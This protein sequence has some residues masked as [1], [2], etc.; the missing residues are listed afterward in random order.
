MFNRKFTST[1]S[2]WIE[3]SCVPDFSGGGGGG[4]KFQPT[5]SHQRWDQRLNHLKG[6][7]IT[8]NPWKNP[9]QLLDLRQKSNNY[10]SGKGFC[11][12]E[13]LHFE[14]RSAVERPVWPQ[15][16]HFKRDLSSSQNQGHDTG[17][18]NML[19]IFT[20]RL[21]LLIASWPSSLL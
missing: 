20:P 17:E 14:F 16:L 19:F 12:L 8:Q 15:M 1:H 13:N 3:P 6:W 10:Q 9:L 21:D 5:N 7:N 4:K 18:T 2:W 11:P